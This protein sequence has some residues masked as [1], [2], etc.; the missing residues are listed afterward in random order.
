MLYIPYI[1]RSI[2]KISK[3]KWRLRSAKRVNLLNFRRQSSYP[4]FLSCFKLVPEGG[5][6]N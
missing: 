3:T 4:N 1:T 6:R 2:P 5:Q